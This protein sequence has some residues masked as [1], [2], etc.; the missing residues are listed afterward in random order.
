MLS[1]ASMHHVKEPEMR[2]RGPVAADRG[3]GHEA[4]RRRH[5]PARAWCEIAVR[6]M[7]EISRT[8]MLMAAGALAF[9]AFLAIPSAFSA[10]VALYGLAFNPSRVAQQVAAL[11]GFMPRE[12]A[13]LIGSQLKSITATSPSRLGIAFAASLAVALWSAR[14]GTASLMSAL[15][16]AYE[17]KEKRS[18]IRFELEALLLIL[19]ITVFAIVLLALVG[20]LPAAIAFLPLG[21]YGKTVAAAIRWPVLIVLMVAALAAIYRFAPSRAE[22]KWRW[23][24]WGAVLAIALWFGGSALFSVYVA[25][26]D[27]YNKTYGSLG[28]VVVLLMWLYVSSLAVLLGAEIDGE[29]EKQVARERA[30]GPPQPTDRRGA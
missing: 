3:H 26:F 14:S 19:A 11:A 23:M 2:G 27:S 5:I 18:L 6:V 25:H 21:P 22:R 30:D 15:D 10:L 4:R 29:I 16:M 13:T 17:E 9:F 20:V 28:A 24:T 8:N 12:A 1:M 7:R